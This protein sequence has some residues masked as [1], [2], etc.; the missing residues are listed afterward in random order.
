[1]NKYLAD[2]NAR[3]IVVRSRRT[4]RPAQRT[5][6]TYGALD[7][8]FPALLALSGD[9]DRARRLQASSFKMW[10]LHGIEPEVID[11]KT[12]RWSP[13]TYHLRPRS[14]NPLTTSITTPAIRSIGSMGEKIFD[15]FVKYC[16]TD[17][18]YAA[19]SDMVHENNNATRWRASFWPRPSNI[20][21]CSSR[22]RTPWI[23]TR[24]SLTRKRT[25][26]GE[27]GETSN[28]LT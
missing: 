24:W 28:I 1:M 11:Y 23:S 7:A 26:C 10:N 8:F 4:C 5:E 14:W 13:R 21:T 22:R 12:M 18:G 27:L 9:L 25:R 16:R 20:S 17:A 3:R 2:D 19:L 15:D 6:T